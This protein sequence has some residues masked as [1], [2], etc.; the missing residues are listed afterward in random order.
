MRTMLKKS[1][2]TNYSGFGL[3]EVII[4]IGILGIIAAG[5]N[6]VMNNL[7][8]ANKK[9]TLDVD[10]EALKL[11]IMSKVSCDDT[12]TTS[13][14]TS[15]A[16]IPLKTRIGGALTTFVD[17]G[18]GTGTKIGGFTIL[19][20]CASSPTT[21]I[22]IRFARLSSS[23][24]LASTDQADFLADPLTG[25][26]I[27]WA[28]DRSLAYKAGITLCAGNNTTSAATL[29]DSP[30][31]LIHCNTYG[32]TD[33]PVLPPGATASG[34]SGTITA[35][36]TSGLPA[37]AKEI[38][39]HGSIDINFGIGGYIEFKHPTH[40]KWKRL[41]SSEGDAFYPNS[42]SVWIPL[43]PTTKDLRWKIY[44]MHANTMALADTTPNQRQSYTVE[45][46][47]YRTN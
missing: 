45:I 23:G 39:L 42:S 35:G 31:Q 46:Q 13:T 10:K 9:I 32:A 33:C 7:M 27:T 6:T 22:E 25:Q 44:T 19:A 16:P 17:G 12:L 21:G 18:S 5:L 2:Y 37:N 15:T 38:L 3:L 29:L 30:I 26:K 11:L 47:G 1:R 8:K 28:D 14:C 36:V 41:I 24:S 4:V 43:D 34:A 20:K 40:T